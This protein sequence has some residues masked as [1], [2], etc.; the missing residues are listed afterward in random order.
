MGEEKNKTTSNNETNNELA[1]RFEGNGATKVELI[2]NLYDI[3]SIKTKT[4][5]VSMHFSLYI[6]WS[7]PR[8]IGK[9]PKELDSLWRPEVVVMNNESLEEFPLD[10]FTHFDTETGNCQI[11]CRYNGEVSVPLK[12]KTF[13]FDEH[14]V[15]IIVAT[16]VDIERIEFSRPPNK[17][18]MIVPPA[19]KFTTQEW[20]I[21]EPDCQVL[22]KVYKAHELGINGKEVVLSR[23]SF[24]LHVSRV[25]SYYFWKI[26][27]VTWLFVVLSWTQFEV[28]PSDIATRM[29]ILLTL[30]LTSVAFLFVAGDSLP[31]ISYLTRMDK[32]MYVS[33]LF[34]F[35]LG[36]ENAAIAKISNVYS[37]DTAIIVD[38]IFFYI[39]ASLYVLFNLILLGRPF[40]QRLFRRKIVTEGTNI[41]LISKEE[42]YQFSSL[43]E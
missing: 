32:L 14:D 11:G 35:L 21:G 29:S 24:S 7:D 6:F 9:N 39:T 15:S 25:V 5:T 36:L 2:C 43:D 13:P 30:F 19:D 28:D 16:P 20:N 8:I 42:K 4:G 17:K 3:R 23:I 37:D 41:P 22:K 40:L 31:K 27:L 34:L 38:N 33:F 26:I 18:P 10:Q 12:L 1:E